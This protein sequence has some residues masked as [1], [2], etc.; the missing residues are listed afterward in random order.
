MFANDTGG[1]YKAFRTFLIV[2]GVLGIPLLCFLSQ[3]LSQDEFAKIGTWAILTILGASAAVEIVFRTFISFEPTAKKL[4]L[5][6]VFPLVLYFSPYSILWY[7]III[8][9]SLLV[10]T[11]KSRLQSLTKRKR[12]ASV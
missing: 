2:L 5:V 7:A 1:C 10:W 8:G 3:G 6:A 12:S 4:W 11:I 9:L